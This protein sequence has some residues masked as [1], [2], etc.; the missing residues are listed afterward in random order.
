[1]FMQQSTF[2]K[3]LFLSLTI[4]LMLSCNQVKVEDLSEKNV[5]LNAPG[6]GLHTT[7]LSHTFHWDPVEGA[8]SY[9]IQIVKPDFGFIEA[10]ILDSITN[11][12]S[13]YYTLFP[14]AFEW[15]VRALN[16]AY[17]SPYTTYQLIID[18]TANLSGMPM[19]LI[20]P[21]NNAITN[22]TTITFRWEEISIA[23]NYHLE[24]SEAEGLNEIVHEG[25]Y[26]G[27]EVEFQMDNGKFNWRVYASNNTPSSSNWSE[28]RA[29]TID[30][31]PPTMPTLLYP[32]Q[33]DSPLEDTTITFQW[34]S[35]IDQLTNVYDSLFI[36]TDILFINIVRDAE[37]PIGQSYSDSLGVGTFYWQV[38]TIDEAGNGT[39]SN[40]S[41]FQIE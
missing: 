28:S 11:N 25:I 13:Y 8:T 26:T 20:S 17:E 16:N 5:L 38:K 24:I 14:G 39:M 29:I 2:R 34:S 31:I 18:S 37:I 6:N 22:Q 3:Y 36:A 33:S 19:N 27:D 4:L 30:S 41:S 15:R 23:D 7:I 40:I 32:T 12:T 10:F 21:P 1:M 35:G 9:Q